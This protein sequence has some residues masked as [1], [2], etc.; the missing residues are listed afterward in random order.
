MLP[1][2]RSLHARSLLPTFPA[3]SSTHTGRNTMKISKTKFLVA[4]LLAGTLTFVGCKSNQSTER[5]EETTDTTQTTP[6]TGTTDQGTTTPATEGSTTGTNPGTGGGGNQTKPSDDNLR[7]PYEDP[8]R[9]P[10]DE[11]VRESES[12]TGVHDDS[13]GTHG[14]G[15]GGAGSDTGITEEP[16]LNEGGNAVDDNRRIPDS[17]ADEATPEDQMLEDDTNLPEGTR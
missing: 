2:E 15:T 3:S 1:V 13:T 17:P 12:E 14:P 8:L 10:E 6:G 4:G 16:S 9:T 5:T 7:M 11:G